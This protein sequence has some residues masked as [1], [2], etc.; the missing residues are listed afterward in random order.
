MVNGRMVGPAA[1]FGRAAE[2]SAVELVKARQL[3]FD[4]V[5][6]PQVAGSARASFQPGSH[7]EAVAFDL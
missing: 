4:V 3:G 6:V 1:V 5:R 2:Y 7:D